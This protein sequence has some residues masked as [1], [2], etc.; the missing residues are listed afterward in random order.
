M[1]QR[2]GDHM[3]KHTTND[4]SEDETRQL[5][6]LA[7]GVYWARSPFHAALDVIAQK[8]PTLDVAEQERLARRVSALMRAA[9]KRRQ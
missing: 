5:G 2:S 3:T 8:Y 9:S 1:K 4:F 6:E 7:R